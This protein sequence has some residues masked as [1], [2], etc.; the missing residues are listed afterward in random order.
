[1]KGEDRRNRGKRVLLVAGF[2]RPK[3][4]DGLPV[5]VGER[6]M[7]EKGDSRGRSWKGSRGETPVKTN[8]EGPSS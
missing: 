2:L 1:M 4:G 5:N 7:E 3:E 6:K 8:K